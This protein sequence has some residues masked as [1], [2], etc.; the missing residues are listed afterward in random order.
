MVYSSKTLQA[1]KEFY[2]QNLHQATDDF[3]GD[4]FD[5]V[6]DPKVRSLS[7]NDF[8]Q[9]LQGLIDRHS[10]KVQSA[11]DEVGS[12]FDVLKPRTVLS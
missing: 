8:R 10:P 4:L 5:Y 1:F 6:V 12:C 11:M 7:R 9:Q 2:K 3:V